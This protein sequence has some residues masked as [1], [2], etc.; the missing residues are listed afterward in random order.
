MGVPVF[1]SS[2]IIEDSGPQKL[3]MTLA[4][5]IDLQTEGYTNLKV[6]STKVGL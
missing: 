3:I 2:H 5:I 1:Q 4:T 6:E